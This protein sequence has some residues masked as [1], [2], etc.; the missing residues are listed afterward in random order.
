MSMPIQVA[1]T[2]TPITLAPA[3]GAPLVDANLRR[4]YLAVQV[5]GANPATVDFG[6]IPTAGAGI[7]LDGG[8]GAATQGGSWEWVFSIPTE[9]LYGFSTAGTTIVVIEGIYQGAVSP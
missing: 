1:M 9:A 5:T 3:A 4:A 6:A 2:S 8:T 7:T